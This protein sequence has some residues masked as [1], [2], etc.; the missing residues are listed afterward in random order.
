MAVSISVFFCLFACLFEI[1]PLFSTLVRKC[2]IEKCGRFFA[3]PG[4]FTF[5]TAAIHLY[6]VFFLNLGWK[7][8]K[9][10][11]RINKMYCNG[12][13]G[14]KC[15]WKKRRE[16]CAWYYHKKVVGPDMLFENIIKRA[17]Y[18]LLSIRW[19]DWRNVRLNHA[20]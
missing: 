4:S 13:I 14:Q 12:W 17:R 1:K 18:E 10:R 9:K 7:R 6:S 15:M 8:R 5:C 2:S 3:A 11:R 16:N 20:F 19:F